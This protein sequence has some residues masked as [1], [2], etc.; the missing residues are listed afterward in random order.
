[1]QQAGADELVT[2]AANVVRRSLQQEYEAPPG[3]VS[4]QERAAGLDM[5]ML[6]GVLLVLAFIWCV[7]RPP[8]RCSLASLLPSAP[9]FA[10]SERSVGPRGRRGYMVAGS[11]LPLRWLVKPTLP[12]GRRIAAEREEDEEYARRREARE[13]KRAELL[14]ITKSVPVPEDPDNPHLTKEQVWLR[15]VKAVQH[16]HS[17]VKIDAAELKRLQSE[18]AEAARLKAMGTPAP[19]V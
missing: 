14:T 4:P 10:R 6:V 16:R 11:P 18:D 3:T 13:A 8:L 15:D 5:F 2:H 17:Q 7:F 12:A 9:A 19:F 1:M